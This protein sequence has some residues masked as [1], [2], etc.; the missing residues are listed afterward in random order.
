[1]IDHPRGNLYLYSDGMQLDVIYYDQP[2][3]D[4]YTLT[5]PESW[6][7]PGGESY[8]RMEF[9]EA[10]EPPKFHGQAFRDYQSARLISNPIWFKRKENNTTC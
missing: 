2:G 3:T 1:M 8:I 4:T 7:A 9:H 10:K 6:I 5:Y